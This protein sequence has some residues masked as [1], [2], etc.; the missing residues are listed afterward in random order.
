M[1]VA[2]FAAV[3]FAAA[4]VIRGQQVPVPHPGF[5]GYVYSGS[6]DSAIKLEAF[7]DLICPDSANSWPGLKGAAARLGP[8]Q[9]QVRI[10]SFPL[11]YHHNGFFAWQGGHYLA[12]RNTAFLWQWL[13]VFYGSAS[14]NQTTYYNAETQD[15][16]PAAVIESMAKLA[17]KTTGGAVSVADFTQGMA[18]DNAFDSATRHSWKY[19]CSR[20]TYG[21]PMF[22]VNGV[23][24]N[25]ALSTW[26]AD[27]WVTAL[28]PYL[29]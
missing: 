25:A 27:Q 6:G 23:W 17:N 9:L 15:M 22:L 1:R 11:P 3:L 26:T 18:Y 5:D 20:G 24:F 8:D 28:T 10:H 19:G 7:Y 29:Q 2:C 12:S 4:S 13:D 14:P 16:T 21:T